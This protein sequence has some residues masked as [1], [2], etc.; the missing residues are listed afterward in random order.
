M[1][2]VYDPADQQLQLYS[3]A[4]LTINQPTSEPTPPPSSVL[5][6]AIMRPGNMHPARKQAVMEIIAQR[7]KDYGIHGAL[8]LPKTASTAS[9]SPEGGATKG[10]A[11]ERL[12][13]TPYGT[14]DTFFHSGRQHRGGMSLEP[15][16]MP[17]ANRYGPRHRVFTI[18]QHNFSSDALPNLDANTGFIMLFK[19]ADVAASIN[20]FLE[21]FNQYR[22]VKVRPSFYPCINTCDN[23][24]YSRISPAK[25]QDVGRLGSWISYDTDAVLPASMKEGTADESFRLHCPFVPF[26]RTFAPK[27][28]LGAWDGM[29][30]TAHT[31]APRGQWVT[32]VDEAAEYFGLR[33]YLEFDPTL[34]DA[35]PIKWACWKQYLIQLRYLALH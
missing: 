9:S 1:R 22:I 2:V 20:T 13:T 10:D 16:A 11:D 3:G 4:V 8:G 23:D 29:A 24:V 15:M 27:L 6:H 35:T 5:E 18:V 21:V 32:S 34:V 25:N 12:G 31:E 7:V 30:Y 33:L 19:I 26:S 28:F 17:K 14:A